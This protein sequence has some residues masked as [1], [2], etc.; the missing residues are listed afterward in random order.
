MLGT[1]NKSLESTKYELTLCK[2]KR[3]QIAILTDAYDIVYD[4]KFL[5]V[6]ELEF[7]IPYYILDNHNQIK[8]PNWDLIKGDYLILVND[9]KYFSIETPK[10]DGGDKLYKTVKCYSLEQE[11]KRKL[12]RGYKFDSR[13]L[14]TEIAE[15]DSNGMYL[16]VLNY[17]ST[18]MTWSI[19]YVDPDLI[20]ISN[21]KYRQFD[22]NEKTIY[23]ALQEIQSTFSCVFMFN[24]LTK[25]IDV[26]RIAEIGMNR[27]LY[28]SEENYIK[29]VGKEIKHGDIVTRLYCYGKDDLTITSKNPCGTP[30]IEDFT[31]YKTTEYMTQGLI[32][33]LNTYEALIT[34]KNGDFS[35][36]LTQLSTLQTSLLTKQTELK[37]LKTE[38]QVIEDNIDSAINTN[39]SYG[40]LYTQQTNKNNQ[41]TAKQAEI[42]TVNA[43]I[44][45]VNNNITT[46]KNTLKKENNFTSEQIVELDYFIREKVWQDTNYIDASDLYEEGK[47]QLYKINQPATN[48]TIDAVDFLNI[49]ECQYDW[50][51]LVLGDIVNINYPKF[52]IDIQVRLVSYTHDISKNTLTLQFSNKNSAFNSD[53]FLE[54]LISKTNS[55]STSIDM[56]KYKWDKAEDNETQIHTILTN[57]WDASKQAVLAGKNQE[58]QINERGI[59]LI[60]KDN[61]DYQ[62]RIISN[63][64][65]IS[66]DGFKTCNLAITPE[67]KCCETIK[68][69]VIKTR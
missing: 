56:S 16:G 28:I 53:L 32:T 3:T 63:V 9:E 25:K 2:P 57:A 44:T 50:D 69:E 51:K 66:R 60:D 4:S 37:T 42:D 11:L 52:N 41:I 10:E 46:L 47:N 24:T 62:M 15:Y 6:D 31:F 12:I 43:N 45:A 13:V 29:T 18:L 22:I 38:L 65:A 20:S 33:A 36:Y 34:S 67:S 14:Y 48:F 30:Y 54:E 26:Y 27:G 1:V 17:I 40:D 58:V 8:N 21:R 7:K 39:T 68:Y 61:P 35:T 5:D 55:S 23:D 64:L 49:V 59:V 19:G